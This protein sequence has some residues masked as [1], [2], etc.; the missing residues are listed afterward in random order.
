MGSIDSQLE[1]G[2]RVLFRTGLH[3]MAF[4]GAASLAAFV[5]L[6]VILLIRHN[7]L[8]P[9]T[10]LE[11]VL[12]GVGVALL[13]VL[14]S[15]LRWRNTELVVTDRRLLATAGSLRRRRLTVPLSPATAEQEA[16]LTGGALDHG[17]VTITGPEGRGSSISHVARAR[18]LVEVARAQARRS[19]RRGSAPS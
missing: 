17:T 8:P 19:P 9:R 15:L 5:A 2:E 7:E 16:G 10:E 11:I 4:S 1:S 13:G 12:A 14:P 18:E 6:V 3:P